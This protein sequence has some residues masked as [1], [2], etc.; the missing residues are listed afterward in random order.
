MGREGFEQL[1]GFHAAPMLLGLKTASLLSFQKSCFEDFEG[2]L[3]SYMQ[4]FSCK[5]IS[6]FRLSEGEEYVLLLFYR[7]GALLKDLAQPAAKKILKKLGYLDEDTLM[8]KLEY[9]KMR[10]QLKKSFPHEVGLFLGYP[11]EDVAGFIRHKGQDFA[12]S[13]YWKVYA[14]ERE[15]RALF[16]LYADCTHDFCLRLEAGE[17]LPDLVKAV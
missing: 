16:D 14:N 8:G 3:A 10:M 9:L 4:C 6:V 1:L 7:R 11:P 5:G 13:G 15:T 17:R 12:Y 2:L